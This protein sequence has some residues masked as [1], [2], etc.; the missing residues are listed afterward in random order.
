M[1]DGSEDVYL[2]VVPRRGS[3]VRW[4]RGTNRFAS[5]IMNAY[6]DGRHIHIDTPVGEKSAFP[7]FPDI[8]GAPFDPEKASA[9]LTR[10]TIDTAAAPDLGDGTTAFEQR[11]LTGCSGE[12]PRTDD[13]W[14]TRGYRF[15]V[16]N[17]TDVP[18]EKPD[19]GLPGFR[20]L[21]QIDPVSGAM[22]TR[23]AGRNSTVQ[24][25]IFVPPSGTDTGCGDGYVMQL[26]DRHE[27]G[28]T[29]LLILDAQRIDEPPVATLK[30]PIRMPGGLHG[31]W[32]TDEQLA[33]TGS[34]KEVA[35]TAE[36]RIA[37]LE[38]RLGMVEDELAIRRLQHAY[39]YYLDKCYYDEVVDLFD[40]D[41]EV[42]FIGGVYKGRA[43]AARLY[44]G[45]FRSRFADGHNGP[46]FGRLL[47]HPML[48]DFI[49][50]AP[51]RRT[52]HARYRTLMQAG[53]HELVAH[54]QRPRSGSG[55][56]AAS[57]RTPT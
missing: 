9:Q 4:Y 55:W 42:I 39:G 1:W 37:E 35:M 44:T 19:D 11:R 36:E 32:V 56:R 49:S 51:D 50:V 46:Q 14:A 12:F 40:E 3:T 8:S 52:A 47:D 48:Q 16:I 15:G 20:W 43:G 38:H 24:E 57:T 45:R 30:I 21:G 5:H 34:N 23:F 27:T 7:W 17:L 26:V 41:C 22:K 2:G 31:N 28:T 13:R 33:A 53:T 54:E 25:A 29:D 10:W 18:G 6:D